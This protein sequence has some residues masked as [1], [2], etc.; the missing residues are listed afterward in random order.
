MMRGTTGPATTSP[1][2]VPD[3]AIADASPRWRVPNQDD[4]RMIDGAIT[5]PLPKPVNRRA[6]DAVAR[7]PERPVSSMPVAVT[8]MPAVT[9]LRAPKREAR[10]P[11]TSAM[12][13]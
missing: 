5:T 3:E 6:A 13:V 11:P 10:K 8:T 9:T 1:R 7:S 2:P 12:T 4:R